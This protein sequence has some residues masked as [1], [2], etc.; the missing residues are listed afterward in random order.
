M[1][2]LIQNELSEIFF[3]DEFGENLKFLSFEPNTNLFGKDHL[4]STVI[5]GTVTISNGSK[6][7]VLIKT[8]IRNPILRERF[9]A[10]IHF[11]NEIIMYEKIIPFFLT[12]SRSIIRDDN[13]PSLVRYF[14]GRNKCGEFSLRDMIILEDVSPLGFRLSEEKLFLDYDHLVNAIQTLAK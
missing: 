13:V 5:F 4:N 11:H 8:K 3:Q 9:R 10:D 1:D 2:L 12:N 7:P 14:Y 6:F